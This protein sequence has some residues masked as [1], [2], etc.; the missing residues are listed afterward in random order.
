MGANL[1]LS[2]PVDARDYSGAAHTLADLGVRFARLTS[3]NPAKIQQVKI[4]GVTVADRVP[5]QANPTEH[6]RAYLARKRDCLGH[7][8][9]LV[10]ET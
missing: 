4:G 6:N 5:L 1:R 8:I 3:N 10:V 9:S 2:L 7:L